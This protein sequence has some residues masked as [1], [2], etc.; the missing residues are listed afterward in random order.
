MRKLF[1]LLIGL[2]MMAQLAPASTFSV[3]ES[4]AD[5]AIYLYGVIGGRSA[6]DLAAKLE[7]MSEDERPIYIVIN[8]PGG[9]VLTGLQI[10]SGI[11]L[12]KS[13]GVQVK[14]LVGMLA[15]SMASI[16]FDECSERYA[17]SQSL[18]LWHSIATNVGGGFFS[19]GVRMTPDLARTMAVSMEMLQQDIPKRLQQHLG[20]DDKTWHYL[21]D[22]ESFITASW[23]HS[24][25]NP[26][27]LNIVSDVEGVSNVLSLVA[28]QKA[29][30]NAPAAPDDKHKP[31]AP[32]TTKNEEPSVFPQGPMWIPSSF[33]SGID[34]DS[35]DEKDAADLR[36]FLRTHPNIGE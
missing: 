35:M 14:C 3:P 8:S 12:A 33:D 17:L 9:E 34:F 25:Y 27:Y 11:R 21:F 1:S 16:I 2:V 13:R 10:V 6:L 4:D 24:Q 19:M 7:K 31:V 29:A 28:P 32:T 30:A 15:A 22:G 20:F 26:H 5:R 23:L 36:E 18:L